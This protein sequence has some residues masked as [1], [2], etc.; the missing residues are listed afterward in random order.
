MLMQGKLYIS[1]INL[2][3]RFRV[4]DVGTGTGTWAIEF[5]HANPLT[6]AIGTDL[7][8]IRSKTSVPA[9]CHSQIAKRRERL[10]FLRAFRL[11]L[12]I[13]GYFIW[14]ARLVRLLPSQL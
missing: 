6:Q 13:H 4:L 12:L 9:N 7:S 14:Y 8:A 5:A 11:H 2:V 1:P 3:R 10:D